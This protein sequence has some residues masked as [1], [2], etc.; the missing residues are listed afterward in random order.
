VRHLPS[1][2]NFWRLVYTS[3]YTAEPSTDVPRRHFGAR[4]RSDR[5]EAAYFRASTKLRKTGDSPKSRG[6][7]SSKRWTCS[8]V[9]E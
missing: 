9:N 4:A 3:A 1:A 7:R 5:E 2:Q 8:G 6:P